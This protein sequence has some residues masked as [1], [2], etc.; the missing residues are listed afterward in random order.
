M[1][2]TTAIE[3]PIERIAE[4][5]KRYR[6]AELSVFGSV[7]RGDFRPDSDVDVLV[8]FEPD[9]RVGY[10]KLADFQEELVDVIGRN[11]DVVLRRGIERS[12]NHVR[13]SAILNSAVPLYVS[14]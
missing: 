13:R 12:Q 14:R 6:V 4:V 11:V 8:T 1:A 10:F 5:C 3:L 9:A 2:P 7:L